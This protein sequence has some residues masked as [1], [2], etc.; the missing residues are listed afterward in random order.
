M[1]KPPP[2]RA[3]KRQALFD[4]LGRFGDGLITREEFDAL[5]REH[6]LTDDDIDR[7]CRGELE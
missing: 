2:P 5:M 4:I 7:F 3:S 1:K 6:R